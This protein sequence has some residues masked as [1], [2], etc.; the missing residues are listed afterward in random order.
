MSN[1]TTSFNTEELIIT[2]IRCSETFNYQLVFE[3]KLHQLSA[4]SVQKYFNETVE[5]LNVFEVVICPT[6]GGK[7][8]TR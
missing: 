2:S 1:I 3:F 4:W 5:V 7:H 6:M 8:V